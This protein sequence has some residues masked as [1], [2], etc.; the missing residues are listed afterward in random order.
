MQLKRAL[1][2]NVYFTRFLTSLAASFIPEGP[3]EERA[4]GWEDLLQYTIVFPEV[5]TSSSNNR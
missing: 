1:A 4:G 5:H 3:R 2:G